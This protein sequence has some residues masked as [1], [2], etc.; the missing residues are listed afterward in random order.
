MSCRPFLM[1]RTIDGSD[2]TVSCPQVL[3]EIVET[4]RALGSPIACGAKKQ[5]FVAGICVIQ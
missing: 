5:E 2:A 4:S 1:L 3:N